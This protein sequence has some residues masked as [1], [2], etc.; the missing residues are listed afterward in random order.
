MYESECSKVRALESRLDAIEVTRRKEA[1]PPTTLA[2]HFGTGVQ[3]PSFIQRVE[4]F[5]SFDFETPSSSSTSLVV[6]SSQCSAHL[7]CR[8]GRALVAATQ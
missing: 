1:L 5:F 7:G 4:R 3:S 2:F 8:Y 6:L